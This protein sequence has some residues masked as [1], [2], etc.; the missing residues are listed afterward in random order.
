MKGFIKITAE[1]TEGGSVTR[2]EVQLQDIGFA[3]K[4]CMLNVF[5]KG[6]QI[7]PPEAELHLAAIRHGLI[8][9]EEQREED[10]E[11]TE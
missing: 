7:S 4:A 11:G 8:R 2:M 3:D 9:P 10:H 1:P 5:L 6:L